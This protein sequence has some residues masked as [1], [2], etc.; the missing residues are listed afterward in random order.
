M[1]R[2]YI[3]SVIKQTI[4]SLSDI[5]SPELLE[6]HQEHIINPKDLD[7]YMRYNYRERR[8]IL[9]QNILQY[10]YRKLEIKDIKTDAFKHALISGEEVVY[11]GTSGDEPHIEVINPLGFFYHK[12]GEKQSGYKKLCMLDTLLL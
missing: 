8:E 12:S 2:N 9:S 4:S 10:L 7:K 5:Y 3:D 11:I 1:L 6:V